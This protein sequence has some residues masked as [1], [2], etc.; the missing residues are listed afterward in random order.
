VRFTQ[1]IREAIL[2]DRFT[3]EFAHWLAPNPAATPV[4]DPS[5]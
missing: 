1:R 2:G 3:D 5:P 4:D